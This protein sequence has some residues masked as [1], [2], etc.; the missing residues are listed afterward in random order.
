M[1][2]RTISIIF[3]I[4]DY[5]ILIDEVVKEISENFRKILF[6]S[7]N[8]LY[9]PL[10]RRLEKIGTDLRKFTFI[11]CVTKTAVPQPQE[12]DDCIYV[13]SPSA[14]TEISIAITKT[15]QNTY[16]DI[17]IFDSLSTLLIYED[18]MTSGQFVHSLTNK[19]NAFGIS[20]VFTI[21]DAEKEQALIK[22]LNMILDKV[23]RVSAPSNLGQTEQQ[24]PPRPQPQPQADS[25]QE[26]SMPAAPEQEPMQEKQ[27]QPEQAHLEEPQE[28]FQQPP[29]EAKSS[30]SASENKPKSQEEEET[31]HPSQ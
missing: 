14:L 30:E 7:L 8:N 17:I 27:P 13:S 9:N 6:V 11:D 25:Q 15:I 5:P 4:K 31:H 28:E 20:A 29:K 18:A 22:D 3:P 1:K 2:N 24:S 19:I 12:H 21:L 23:I 16:P 10:K 26:Q